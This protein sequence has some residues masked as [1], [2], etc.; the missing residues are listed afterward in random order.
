MISHF[1]KIFIYIFTLQYCLAYD[2]TLP[3]WTE[4][5]F[6]PK[7]SHPN[8]RYYEKLHSSQFSHHI[9]K[10]GLKE[11][12]HRFNKIKEVSFSALGRDFR[13]ILNPRKGLL[14]PYFKAYVVDENGKEKLITVDH[15][16]FYEGRVFGENSSEVSAHMEDGSYDCNN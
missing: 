14:D 16:Y 6:Q 4:G 13:L 5:L 11:S 8:L 12:N 15:E 10:R 2:F 1:Y 7:S 9:V 3:S